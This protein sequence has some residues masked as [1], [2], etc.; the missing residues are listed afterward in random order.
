MR[1]H[2]PK[3][4]LESEDAAVAAQGPAP[5][6]DPAAQVPTPPT[7]PEN[8]TDPALAQSAELPEF[9]EELPD[10]TAEL[11]ECE[12]RSGQIEEAVDV[13]ESLLEVKD[14]LEDE[15]SEISEAAVK[16]AEIATEH[17]FASIGYVHPTPALEDG[18][19]KPKPSASDVIKKIT[20][21]AKAIWEKIIK[22]IERART[23]LMEFF[24]KLIDFSGHLEKRAHAYEK[25]MDF[26]EGAPKN[27]IFENHSLAVA[28]QYKQATPKDL[29]RLAGET[30]AILSNQLKR[31]DLQ[32]TD[33]KK[34]AEVLVNDPE[35]FEYSIKQRRAASGLMHTSRLTGSWGNDVEIAHSDA[36]LGGSLIVEEIGSTLVNRFNR[37]MGGTKYEG[38]VRKGHHAIMEMIQTP[39]L[40]RATAGGDL[41]YTKKIDHP[42]FDVLPLADL[43]RL[44]QEVADMAGEVQ[45]FRGSVTKLENLCTDLVKDCKRLIAEGDGPK[46][47]SSNLSAAAVRQFF[48]A[49]PRMFIEEPTKFANELLRIGK[50]L[51]KY[52]EQAAKQYPRRENAPEKEPFGNDPKDPFNTNV[53]LPSPAAA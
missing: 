41:A 42:V 25:E 49:A 19:E 18:E 51:L 24:R 12:V 44:T 39:R 13:T 37:A 2:L 11:E 21:G 48:G 26:R 47:T 43:K 46:S 20:D 14:T 53:A 28:L 30:N 31:V 10:Y 35:K 8:Q 17:L 7:N 50:A 4:A 9:H 23:W 3:P 5:A 45:Q 33:A 29:V 40:V 32:T 52:T 27:K 15:S 6:G 16:I 22:A 34:M 36:I 1:R 38:E